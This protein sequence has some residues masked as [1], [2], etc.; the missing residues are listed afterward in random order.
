V[1]D[2]EK[3]AACLS[4]VRICPYNVPVIDAEG[5]ADIEI[6][7]CQGCG[8]CASECPAQAISLQHFTSEQINAKSR[9]LLETIN[10]A[11]RPLRQHKPPEPPP[12]AR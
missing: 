1:V 3:C 6:A 4:C 2:K 9:A 11:Q 7:R 12:S 5:A 8:I 10:G